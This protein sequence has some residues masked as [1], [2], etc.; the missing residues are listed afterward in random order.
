M[1][2]LSSSSA[3]LCVPLTKYWHAPAG[4]PKGFEQELP[5][6]IVVEQ[7]YWASGKYRRI[8]A[9][10]RRIHTDTLRD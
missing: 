2:E 7:R 5:L 6:L 4:R 1:M 8:N 3:N 10:H 9:K